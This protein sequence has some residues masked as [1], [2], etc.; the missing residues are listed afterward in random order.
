ML[1]FQ[2]DNVFTNGKSV[3][4]MNDMRP[5]ISI[6]NVS[7]AMAILAGEKES[8][9]GF[10]TQLQN[11]VG[12]KPAIFCKTENHFPVNSSIVFSIKFFFAIQ[13]YIYRRANFTKK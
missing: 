5:E 1:F 9:T 3:Y 10:I 6:V 2:F 13:L 4:S 12:A 7:Y 8:V 11:H